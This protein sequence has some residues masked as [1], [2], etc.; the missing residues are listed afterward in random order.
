MD[1]RAVFRNAMSEAEEG[2]VLGGKEMTA[3]V[4]EHLFGL[5]G[6]FDKR[7]RSVIARR[8]EWR[9]FGY[10]LNAN[11][12]EL[13]QLL[14]AVDVGLPLPEGDAVAEVER[15]I[16]NCAA[17]AHARIDHHRRA[18]TKE[19]EEF[20]VEYEKAVTPLR[21]SDDHIILTGLRNYATHIG[22][23]PVTYLGFPGL[24]SLDGFEFY[25]HR[26]ELR[27]C[28]H[29][30]TIRNRAALDRQAPAIEVRPLVARYAEHAADQDEEVVRIFEKV[31]AE[32]LRADRDAWAVVL[33][34]WTAAGFGA[35]LGARE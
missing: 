16:F 1:A 31:Y 22:L 25:M 29:F 8:E 3:E 26:D 15:M 21:N 10:V 33:T 9:R 13:D 7:D 24:G 19:S 12:E 28:S 20:K 32:E 11:A 34:A 4:R 2:A 18:K 6:D 27:R 14:G 5:L 30:N 23:T 17:A 35:W